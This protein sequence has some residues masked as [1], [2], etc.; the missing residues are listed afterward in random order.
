MSETAIRLGQRTLHHG[1]LERRAHAAATGLLA[2]GIGHE[3]SVAL[4]L[5]NDLVLFE[6]VAATRLA[7][8]T[9][10]PLNWHLTQPEI[11]DLLVDS[12]A[13]MVVVH[14]DLLPAIADVIPGSA[15]VR[16]VSTPAEIATAHGIA[17]VACDVPPGHV[18]WGDWVRAHDP[19]QSPMTPPGNLMVYTPGISGQPNGVLRLALSPQR[20][21]DYY[22]AL[23]RAFGLRSG[24]RHLV[25]GPLYHVSPFGN[26]QVAVWLGADIDLMARFD[27][28]EL[29]RHI[30]A[31]RISHVHLVPSMFACLLALPEEDRNRFDLSSL[32]CVCHGAGPCPEPVKRAMIEWWGPLFR[33]YYGSTEASVVAGASSEDWLRRPG[34]LGRPFPGAR[35]EIRDNQGQPAPRG[36]VGEIW[37]RL[38]CAPE[39]DY[40][41]RPEER[42]A[43]ESDGL[44]SNGDQ[45]YLDPEGYLY[46]CKQ[47]LIISAGVTISAVEVEAVLMEHPEVAGCAVFGV[48]SRELGEGVAAAVQPAPGCS[49]DADALREFA[50]TRLA[51]YK[52]PGLIQF[53]AA[54][55]RLDNG[56]IY[57]ERL[58]EPH[59]AEVVGN[60][61]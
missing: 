36:Q 28:L 35:L 26:A 1:Q 41:G 8:A 57:K 38:S 3:Q 33:E 14:A 42:R 52:L 61:A 34:S 19:L 55:P 31:R 58:R 12:G 47:D 50:R 17:G 23:A 11:G 25:T 44:L 7:G 9:V 53:H 59:W 16:V 13:R 46:V 10:V 40:H 6:A 45:G 5:R 15:H 18:A 20:V 24:M 21:T 43:I 27:A 2:L 60:A 56:K 22:G 32:E 48:P 37:A 30:E 4:V 51:A 39:F 54:L 49:P 29:L